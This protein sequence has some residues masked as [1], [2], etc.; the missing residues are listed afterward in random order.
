MSQA[1]PVSSPENATGDVSTILSDKVMIPMGCD[2]C[3]KETDISLHLLKSQHF[4]LCEHCNTTHQV[5]ATELR[6]MRMMLARHGY[7]FAL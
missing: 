7:H 1:L 5:S 6:L 4:Y 3:G 2:H